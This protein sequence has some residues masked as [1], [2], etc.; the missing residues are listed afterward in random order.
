MT[1]YPNRFAGKT[2]VVTGAAQGIGSDVVLRLARERA[3]VP[4]RDGGG[5]AAPRLPKHRSAERTGEGL[6]PADRG[7]SSLFYSLMKRFGTTGEQAAAILFLAS[8]EASAAY[9]GGA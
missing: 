8:D 3:R 7:S 1:T 5:A 2:A 9:R 6:V 4:R